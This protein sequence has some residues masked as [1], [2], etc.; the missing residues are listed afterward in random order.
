M[1]IEKVEMKES[2]TNNSL[3]INYS[4]FQPMGNKLFP[5]NG[6]INLFYK[7]LAGC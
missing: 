3:V 1:K 4:N 2:N 6:T 5:Y 7:T